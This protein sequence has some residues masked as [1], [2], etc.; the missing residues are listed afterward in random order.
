MFFVGGELFWDKNLGLFSRIYCG[1]FGV[2]ISGLR[3]RLRRVLP[4]LTGTPEKVLDAGC[5][6]GVFSYQL[7]KRFPKAEI[8]AV[9]IDSSQ[10]ERN[11]AI[12]AKAKLE[13][14]SF[15]ENDISRLT[16]EDEFDL[17]LSVDNLEHLEDD[18]QGLMSIYSALK[19]NG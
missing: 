17:V 14:V 11:A 19:Q 2:P 7:A 4:S 9:D 12:A 16:F 10:L 1:L 18:L 5:G 3:I 15:V 13:N 6:R 8:V